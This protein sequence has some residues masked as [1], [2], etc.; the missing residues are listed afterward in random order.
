[1]VLVGTH[2]PAA[3]VSG[4]LGV[5]PVNVSAD[6]T[7]V[8]AFRDP[9][10]NAVRAFSRRVVD[11]LAPTFALHPDPRRKP[12]A[13]FIDADTNTSWNVAGVAVDGAKEFRGRK[14]SPVPA[15]DD[16]Y[17]GVMKH[18][19]PELRLVVGESQ[20]AEVVRASEVLKAT[21]PRSTPR[22]GSRRA[23]ASR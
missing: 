11:D 18:W 1:V 20:T 3:V 12:D 21:E 22:R 8:M 10:T 9:R 23:A 19:Y 16:L 17:W 5:S 4:T 13:V 7:P 2:K 15:E 6:G 14:L